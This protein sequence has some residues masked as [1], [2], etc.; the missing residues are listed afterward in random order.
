M[1]IKWHICLHWNFTQRY[2]IP[3]R[4]KG[5]LSLSRAWITLGQVEG[6]LPKGPYLPC[7]SMA[8]RALLAGYHRSAIE[9]LTKKPGPRLNIKTLFPRYGDS[10][11]KDKTVARPSYLW[12][13]NPC[14]DKMIYLYWDGPQGPINDDRDFL[15]IPKMFILV[16]LDQRL[17]WLFQL[18]LHIFKSHFPSH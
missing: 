2:G 13:R 5:S 3:K 15:R 9:K 7:V 14:T 16:L 18:V 1:S 17:T 12:H 8:G 6:I 10:H 11:D 4:L